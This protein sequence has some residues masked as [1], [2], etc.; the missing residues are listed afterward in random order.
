[1]INASPLILLG[2]INQLSLLY[3]LETE[4]IVPQSVMDEIKM[5][6]QEDSSVPMIINWSRD[7]TMPDID[8]APSILGWDLGQG[9]TQVIS[10][11][12]SNQ[13]WVILDDGEARAAAK[14][15]QIPIV[16]SL[17]I[18]LRARQKNHIPAARA[19]IEQL[20]A[21]GSYLSDELVEHALRKVGE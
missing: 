9:E 14:S 5:G 4:V 20:V 12:Y 13:L 17:G 6:A 19:L 1:M 11:A 18:I 21:Q 15:H 16:G 2:K 8:I 10:Y 7:R 3:V